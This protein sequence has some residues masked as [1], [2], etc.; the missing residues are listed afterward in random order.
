MIQWFF[1]DGID[2]KPAGAAIGC[3]D[4][5]VI[6]AS[7]DKTESALAFSELA[8]TG[9]DVTLQPTIVDFVPVSSRYLARVDVFCSVC[10]V[11]DHRNGIGA[12]GPGRNGQETLLLL[13]WTVAQAAKL[14][15]VTRGYSS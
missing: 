15:N 12:T 7:A 13:L 3:Q 1:L 11:L 14:D 9:T 6:R 8:E 5:F 10:N 4:N 2:A